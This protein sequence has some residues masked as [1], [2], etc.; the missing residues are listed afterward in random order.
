MSLLAQINEKHT[1]LVKE[2]ENEK[3]NASINGTR[4]NNDDEDFNT[5]LNNYAKIV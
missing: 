4:K 5:L 1:S 3:Q 2:E